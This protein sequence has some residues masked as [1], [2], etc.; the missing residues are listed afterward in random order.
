MRRFFLVVVLLLAGCAL[1]VATLPWWLGVALRPVAARYGVTFGRYERVGY[2]RFRV[3]DVRVD[4]GTSWIAIAR[5][6]EAPTVLP[7]VLAWWG[8]TRHTANVAD[9]AVIVTPRQTPGDDRGSL[10][11]VGLQ[12]RLRDRVRPV[13]EHLPNVEGG[14]GRV[15]WPGHEIRLEQVTWHDNRLRVAGGWD[16]SPPAELEAG[17]AADRTLRGSFRVDGDKFGGELRLTGAEL[18]GRLTAWGNPAD[19]RARFGESGWWPAEAQVAADRWSVPA[20]ELKLEK[21]YDALQGGFRV[22]WNG[23]NFRAETGFEAR[24]LASDAPPV[25]VEARASGDF[26]RITVDA[27]RLRAPWGEATLSAPVQFDRRGQLRGGASRFDFHA[28][29]AGLPWILARGE[30]SGHAEIGGDSAVK[31]VLA[32]SVQG[33]QVAW[34]DLAVASASAEGELAWPRLTLRAAV[35]DLGAAGHLRGAGGMDFAA[36][37]LTA[38]KVDGRLTGKELARWLPAKLH[39]DAVEG[40]AEFSGPWSALRHAGQLRATSVEWAPLK[41]ALVNAR[42]SG[43]GVALEKLEGDATWGATKVSVAGAVR[44]TELQLTH[45]ELTRG[46]EPRWRLDTPAVLRWRPD[47]TLTAARF[48]GPAGTIAGEWSAQGGRLD[49]DLRDPPLDW[50]ADAF[51]ATVPAAVR[52]HQVKLAGQWSGDEPARATLEAAADYVTRGGRVLSFS[53][54]A[55]TDGATTLV[56]RLDLNEGTRTIAR[57][58]GRLPV[59]V[60]PGSPEWWRVDGNAPVD[61]E[62]VTEAD[63]E[64]WDGLTAMAGAHLVNPAGRLTLQGTLRQPRGLLDLTAE[65]VSVDEGKAGARPTVENLKVHAVAQED[66]IELEEFSFAVEGQRA[67]ATGRLPL[68]ADLW[69]RLARDPVAFDWKRADVRFQVNEARLAPFA[70]YLPRFLAP[71]GSLTVDLALRPGGELA[72]RMEIANAAT[73]PLGSL[74]AVQDVSAEIDFK[75]WRADFR[76]VSA[77]IGGEPLALEGWVELPKDRPP[78]VNATLRGQNIPVA[79]QPGLVVRSDLD[80]KVTTAEQGPTRLSG[81]LQLR[82]SLYVANLRSFVPGEKTSAPARRPPYFSIEVEPLNQWELDVRVT[83]SRFLRVRT[84]L[85]RGVVSAGFRLAGTMADPVATGEA[86]IDEGTVLFPFAGFTV[87]HG[88]VALTPDRPREPQL[89]VGGTTLRYGYDLRMDLTGTAANP[90]VV[91]SSR[92]SL[93]SEQILLLVMAGEPPVRTGTVTTETSSQQRYAQI[94][95]YLGRNLFTTFGGDPEAGDRLTVTTG[96][97]ISRQGQETLEVE[98]E[99]GRRWSLV[100]EYDEYDDYNVGL[101]YKVLRGKQDESRGK[102]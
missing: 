60:R 4:R 94:G 14:N 48:T 76:R 21:L 81:T 13:L 64:F 42:W 78:R 7:W 98:Y 44:A 84:P 69:Q 26:E 92:P 66:G 52:W 71:Q 58:H 27:L 22:E 18:E 40:A 87:D 90:N 72:G 83:G 74:G 61:F 62:A 86:R 38:V 88:R 101:K 3:T 16:Q 85:F 99:L 68:D 2:G 23:A 6:V 73:R 25:T 20:T 102:K 33:S 15:Q 45:A 80:L 54:N 10:G 65:S 57:A 29:L 75:G 82:D 31:P 47:L 89:N 50:I 41:P 97:R 5:R 8:G 9:W 34:R 46:G 28:D 77:Q 55:K 96:A 11:W 35:L 12:K 37:Q 24:P 36:R 17:Y 39:C 49:A 56:E 70:R 67:A 53:A 51:P 43:E 100:G 93:T 19:V 95:A 30:V 1:L 59:A 79:R 32:F 63:R 91:F